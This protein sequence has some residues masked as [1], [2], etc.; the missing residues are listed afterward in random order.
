MNIRSMNRCA[1]QCVAI[2]LIAFGFAACQ[3]SIRIGTAIHVLEHRCATHHAQLKLV[4]NRD[5]NAHGECV[6]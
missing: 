4:V 6:R 3:P 1:L 2:L 5:G